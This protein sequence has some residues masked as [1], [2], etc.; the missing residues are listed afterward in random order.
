MGKDS[1]FLSCN[2]GSVLPTH[3]FTSVCCKRFCSFKDPIGGVDHPKE[4]C[5]RLLAKRYTHLLIYQASVAAGG[6]RI[7]GKTSD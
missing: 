6:G 3:S 5:A 4:F 1:A 7:T 2:W